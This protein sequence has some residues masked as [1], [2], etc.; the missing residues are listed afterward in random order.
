ME[1]RYLKKRKRRCIGISDNVYDK[2]KYISVKDRRSIADLIEIAL[3]TEIARYERQHGEIKVIH[4]KK[5]E[6]K[7]NGDLLD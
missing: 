6:V 4:E 3:E 2:I 5:G 7:F 1:Q